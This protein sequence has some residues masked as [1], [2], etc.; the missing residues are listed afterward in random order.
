MH[1][2]LICSKFNVSQLMT[3]NDNKW[4]AEGEIRFGGVV[5]I[6]PR[7]YIINY[8]SIYMS[9]LFTLT[10]LNIY[11]KFNLTQPIKIND[12]FKSLG[13][14]SILIC[15]LSSRRLERGLS[16]FYQLKFCQKYYPML[17]YNTYISI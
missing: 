1:L 10:Y 7:P 2:I 4:R 17:K 12:I 15:L 8:L 9:H 6:E 14:K 11:V 3:I 16:S 13:K 5:P